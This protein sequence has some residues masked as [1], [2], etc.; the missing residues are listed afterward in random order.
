VLEE[1]ERERPEALDVG[2]RELHHHRAVPAVLHHRHAAQVVHHPGR[3]L[4]VHRQ[5]GQHRL[6]LA[7]APRVERPAD[8]LT[9]RAI[10]RGPLQHLDLAHH[11][12]EPEDPLVVAAVVVTGEVPAAPLE[13]EAVGVDRASLVLVGE[14]QGLAV[15]HRPEDVAQVGAAWQGQGIDRRARRDGGAVGQSTRGAR[16]A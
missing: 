2:D 9:G 5:L 16:G 3:L 6:A 11:P 13:V 1:G 8:P 14:P 7:Q 4:G 10:E 12:V 15:Q